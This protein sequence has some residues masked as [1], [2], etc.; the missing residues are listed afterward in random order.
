[1][2]K[3]I[4]VRTKLTFNN[5]ATISVIFIIVLSSVTVIN[6]RS[7]NQNIFRSERNIRNSLII[8][9]NTLTN[10]NGMAMTGMA[11]D[12]AVT[13]VRNLV[14]SAIKDD[15]DII[16]G[17][18]MDTDHIAW[19]YS[20]PE[21]LSGAPKNNAPLE[22][23][24]SEWAGSL[25]K[26]DHRIYIRQGKEVIEFAAPVFFERE[27]LGFIRYGISTESM[28]KSVKETL[29]EGIR[30]RNYTIAVLLCFG[31]GS[32]AV[33]YFFVRRLSAKIT[34]P[35]DSLVKSAMTI[36]S[37][38]YD[39]PVTS[40]SNDELGLLVKDVDKMRKAIKDLT[41]NLEAKVNERT[42]QL[43]EANRKLESAMDALWGE[44]ELA[45]KIQTVL[46]P[47]KPEISGYEIAASCEPSEEVGGD[48]Y[49]IISVGGF[50]WIVIGDV[51]GHGVT[52]GLVM[53][54]VQTAI[55][56]VL[57]ENP[58]VEPSRLLSVINRTI[59]SNIE[60]MSESKHMTIIVLAA[61]KEGRFSFSGLHE[62]ILIRRAKTGKVEAV[63]SNGMW[64][65][66]EPDISGYLSDDIL[67][68]EPGDCMVLFTDGITEA[69]C[70][71]GKLFGDDRLIEVIEESGDKSAA[72]IRENI[73]NALESCEKPDDVTLVVMKR[74]SYQ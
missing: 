45:K 13:A 72:E 21:N 22:D 8:K 48:Y 26:P 19:A 18:Y 69:F 37:G 47:K 16:Y 33:S 44:M 43:Q 11:E 7:L 17:I 74:I 71:E 39:I 35:I 61:G 52:A 62:D 5:M 54:M 59:Y 65:G 42:K 2:K 50:D 67:K 51:S 57:N 38:N 3:F 6:I 66:L 24:L 56:T 58:Q 14:S 10:N 12:N 32:L 41:E 73:I 20:T 55:H 40:E 28:Q 4:S 30:T 64:I 15:P 9:G 27:I 53:M 34:Q 46:L 23:E 68:M 36:A 31:I 60:R 70:E 1:M 63:K 49:D 29:S 25:K